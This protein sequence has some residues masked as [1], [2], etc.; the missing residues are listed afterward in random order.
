M[1]FLDYLLYCAIYKY[2]G[3]VV[4][5]A[6]YFAAEL[7]PVICKMGLQHK[8]ICF[9]VSQE[10]ERKKFEDF[11]I[12]QIDKIQCDKERTLVLTAVTQLYQDEVVMKS[13]EA[14]FKNII[15]GTDYTR[16]S[17]NILRLY[18][19]AEYSEFIK[20][21]V[22]TVNYLEENK[23]QDM[24][25][26]LIENRD[27]S[28]FEQNQI[29]YISGHLTPRN[30]KMINA[31]NRQGFE[32]VVIFYCRNC[33][34]IFLKELDEIPYIRCEDEIELTIAMLKCHPLAFF[35]EPKWGDC[36]WVELILRYKMHFRPIVLGL[37]DVLNDGYVKDNVQLLESER[38]ALEHSDGI[39]WRWYSKEYLEQSKKFQF[40]GKSIQ[41][42]DYCG[43]YWRQTVPGKRDNSEILKLCTIQGSF[44]DFAQSDDVPDGYM[45]CAPLD[46][47]LE[48]LGNDKRCIL[49]IF[50]GR[51]DQKAYEVGRKIEKE[52]SNIKIFWNVNHRELIE[53]MQEYDYGCEFYNDGTLIPM[54]QGVMCGVGQYYGSTFVNCMGNKY[55]DY[56]DA[57]LPIIA[58]PSYKLMKFLSQYGIVVHMPMEKFDML[59]LNKQKELLR[60]RA[61]RARECLNIDNYISELSD[62]FREVG[63]VQEQYI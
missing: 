48:V 39:V 52:Y 29:V 45:R 17:E 6:G 50:I 15:L 33:P 24:E 47:I 9:A 58:A 16:T 46:N 7:Y 60:N 22:H 13:K 38:Y 28:E 23:D 59:S 11:R 40:Q 8:I 27:N 30:T 44:W 56:I 19:G 51:N 31:L 18:Q 41:F 4:Y 35:W 26:V 3:F 10:G 53:K 12:E 62:F 1:K 57:G 20:N 34:E 43:D 61:E 37:Y 2:D 21:I 25:K 49:H 14:G 63:N 42:I 36:R 32:L 5:G 54:E 55:F